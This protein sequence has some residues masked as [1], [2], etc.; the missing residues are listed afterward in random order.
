MPAAKRRKV[1]AP[2]TSSSRGNLDA[3]ARVSK[4]RSATSKDISEKTSTGNA[5]VLEGYGR[6]KRRLV[7]EKEEDVKISTPTPASAEIVK[8]RA[9]RPLPVT[10]R[11]QQLFETPK[12]PASP[13]TPSTIVETPTTKAANLFNKVSLAK[14]SPAQ[15]DSSPIRQDTSVFDDDSE[16]LRS[17]Q[18]SVDQGHPDADHLLPIELSDLINLHASFLNALSLHYAHNGT[19]TPADVREL[20]PSIALNWGKRAVTLLDVQR[21]LGVQ[22]FHTSEFSPSQSSRAPEL[23]L[24]NYGNGKI[25][26][27]METIF[28]K[29]GVMARPLNEQ[30]LTTQY[31]TNLV[32]LWKQHSQTAIEICKEKS[33]SIFIDSLPLQP[34]PTNTSL[35][36]ISPTFA[37][38]AR[39]LADLKASH[40][41][42]KSQTT[43]KKQTLLLATSDSPTSS[44]VKA[45][46]LSRNSSLLS[47]IRAKSAAS[48]L[49]PPPPSKTDR[50]RISALH[51]LPEVIQI[52]TVM[53]TSGNAGQSRVSFSMGTVLGR[54]K[55]S[56]RGEMGIEEGRMCLEVLG[57][58]VGGGWVKVVGGV[59][60]KG[61]A[62]VVN[63]ERRPDG[64]LIEERI[65]VAL[66]NAGGAT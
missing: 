37:K 63:R 2:V 36:K 5:E 14:S 44:P 50:L 57:G 46:P 25:C 28:G 53:S 42:K 38:G 8:N 3:F 54:L 33:I 22:N 45:S 55:D 51:R 61:G 43:T 66:E 4:Q 49:L 31:T 13:S 17:S 6:G 26:I 24:S 18:I 7:E 16:I 58:E 27:E 1:A 64:I 11:S 32:A 12:K 19:H 60:G 23:T 56:C 9:I 41:L 30:G 48:L 10:R 21:A 35:D 39:R 65:K 40:A 29:K 59:G 34:I 47:R 15:W 20:R 62:L 52:L